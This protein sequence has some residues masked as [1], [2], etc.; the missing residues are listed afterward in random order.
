MSA[1]VY[2]VD[3]EAP[4]R[5]SLGLLVTSVGFEVIGCEDAEAFEQSYDP[6]RAGC[7]LLDVRMPRMGGLELL[8]VL[9]ERGE[10]V[11]V[12]MISGHAD[13]PTATKAMLIGASDFFE[14]PFSDQ[15][16]IDRI[17]AAV[18]GHEANREH[19]RELRTFRDRLEDLS[20]R[21]VEV[22]QG[23]A[24]GETSVMIAE[25]LG[26][27]RRTVEM[28]RA[29]LMKKLD[30]GSLAELVRALVEIERD[31]RGDVQPLS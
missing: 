24:A 12:I 14:K 9:R 16:L 19:D 26:L 7:V 15:E 23:L 2:I 29:R 30:A 27:S 10:T 11:P 13:V 22:M 18:S 20:A 28:H 3:D 5:E 8:R 1:I 6:D 31:T 21:E 17:N 4:M 25:R